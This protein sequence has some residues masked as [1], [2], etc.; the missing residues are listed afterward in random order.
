MK[1]GVLKIKYPLIKMKKIYAISLS[2]ICFLL[3]PN[4]QSCSKIDDIE[5]EVTIGTEN[6]GVYM[7][8]LTIHSLD[9]S[10]DYRRKVSVQ[11]NNKDAHV[12]LVIK[13]YPI[14]GNK[15]I[16]LPITEVSATIKEYMGPV[17]LFADKPYTYET[18]EY[19]LKLNG[20]IINKV[21]K[22]TAIFTPVN[23]SEEEET[24][25]DFE[26]VLGE[27]LSSST[28]I[29]GFELQTEY[30]IPSS[31]KIDSEAGTIYFCTTENATDA[32]LKSILPTIK[33]A[34]GAT[35]QP[36]ADEPQDFSKPVK[37]V[38]TSEDKI[39]TKTYMVYKL[40][41][42]ELWDFENWIIANPNAPHLASQYKV[43]ESL[44]GFSWNSGDA[45]IAPYMNLEE[46]SSNDPTVPVRP[47]DQF[48]VTATNDSYQG[49]NAALIQTLKLRSSKV[50]DIPSI[51]GGSLYTGKYTSEVTH[52]IQASTYGYPIHYKPMALKGYFKYERGENYELCTNIEKPYETISIPD[53]QDAFRMLLILYRVDDM[54]DETEMLS[55]LDIMNGS[56]KIIATAEWVSS[57][58]KSSY[59]AFEL[60][61]VYQDA[62]DFSYT[63]NH[64]IALFFWS[65]AE[66]YLYSGAP[67]SKLFLD[68]IELVTE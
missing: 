55:M 4:L 38:V 61:L 57:E 44:F 17:T 13:D 46:T 47:A 40:D 64:R 67:G 56:D 32:D 62:K 5:D 10:A 27:E 6:D 42:P 2:L 9:N 52:P 25:I 59:T 19:T 7:G 12:D 1:Y 18:K 16:N 36:A 49:S 50:Y 58:N 31:T 29:Y 23:P 39:F 30:Y 24:K 53:K 63:S 43:P 26:G 65:S 41:R 21:L 48:S 14:T 8:G 28:S 22:F 11:K 51:L 37:Y 20:S 15:N 3:L 54:E 35:I 68:N 34:T 45:L 60:P 33:L 66:S